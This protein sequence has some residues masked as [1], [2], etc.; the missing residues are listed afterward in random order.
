MS[1]SV[2]SD[3]RKFENESIFLDP[4]LRSPHVIHDDREN[5]VGAK[6]TA[7][8][9]VY[10]SDV[11]LQIDFLAEL[12]DIRPRVFAVG[13]FDA[14]CLV[15]LRH[16]DFG[17]RHHHSDHRRDIPVHRASVTSEWQSNVQQVEGKCADIGNRQVV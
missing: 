4:G 10:T 8:R 16:H 12:F 11:R 17:M 9:D 6:S 2:R 1:R 13:R 5:R 7:F 15:E 14:R 3:A